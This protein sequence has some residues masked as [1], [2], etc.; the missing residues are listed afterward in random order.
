MLDLECRLCNQDKDRDNFSTII[1]NG[2]I[3]HHNA[4]YD[5]INTHIAG[6][7]NVSEL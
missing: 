5:C 2:Y 1:Q 7:W 4:T 3:K 6:H